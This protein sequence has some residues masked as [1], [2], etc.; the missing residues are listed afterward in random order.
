LWKTVHQ[1]EEENYLRASVKRPIECN[2]VP[3]SSIHPWSSKRRKDRAGQD[4]AEK[5]K[6]KKGVKRRK[7]RT[8]RR[9]EDKQ[10]ER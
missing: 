5:E 4:R 7:R 8:K 10:N 3:S 9:N 2:V 1:N 6:D